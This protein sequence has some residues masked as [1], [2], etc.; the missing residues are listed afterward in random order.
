M[1]KRR[2]C[3]CA[4]NVARD[5]LALNHRVTSPWDGWREA[6]DAHKALVHDRLETFDGLALN[7]DQRLRK[8]V[9]F[10]I[11]SGFMD[12]NQRHEVPAS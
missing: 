5:H 8:I 6:G 3:G 11:P 10:W 12:V 4:V 9:P 7:P 2:V 1:D